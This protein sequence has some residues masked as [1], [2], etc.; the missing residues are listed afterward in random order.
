MLY[1]LFRHLMADFHVFAIDIIGMGSS[2]RPL[3]DSQNCE[4]ADKYMM[5]FLEKWRESVLKDDQMTD[6]VLVG[7][8]YGGY[9]S[10]TYAK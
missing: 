2:S 5:H 8:S 6:F 10:G 9:I 7:H 1:R 4:E 3:F